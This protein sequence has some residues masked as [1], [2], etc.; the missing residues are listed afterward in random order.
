MFSHL[1]RSICR[2]RM[3]RMFTPTRFIVTTQADY[4]SQRKSLDQGKPPGS[5]QSGPQVAGGA[6][7][8]LSDAR[9]PMPGGDTAGSSPPRILP[10]FREL[11][12]SVDARVSPTHAPRA[13]AK[14][15]PAAPD[16]TLPA[17]H[18][19]PGLRSIDPGSVPPP[20]ENE[21]LKNGKYL[22]PTGIEYLYVLHDVGLKVK[23]TAEKLGVDVVTVYRHLRKREEEQ[24]SSAINPS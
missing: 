5:N 14:A 17:R 12:A 22:T 1:I 21:A 16:V 20:P 3:C 24:E 7:S 18:D 4:A 13:P 11:A 2:D 23:D 6:L 8:G 9:A 15:N 19:A 10:S